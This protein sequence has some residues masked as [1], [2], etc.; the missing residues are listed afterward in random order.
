[1]AA[2]IMIKLPAGTRYLTTNSER[3]A[4][5][6]AEEVINSLPRDALPMPLPV[7]CA[8]QGFRIRLAIYLAELQ[9]EC[10]ASRSAGESSPLPCG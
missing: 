7:A 1:M 3:S 10:M 5:S 4:A 9:I 6:F 8:D 2:I